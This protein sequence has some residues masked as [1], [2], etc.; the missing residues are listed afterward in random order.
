M[1]KLPLE[2]IRV[3]DFTTARA[4]S[5]ISQW[6]GIMGAEVLKIESELRPDGMR[7][8]HRFADF[9]TSKKSITLNMNKPK[10]A[11]LVK[12]LVKVSD[13]VADNFGGAVMERWGLGYSE[14]KKIKPSII[15]YTGCGW[16]RTGPY[17]ER[18]A[19]AP[20]I[21]AFTGFAFANGYVGGPPLLIGEGGW[22]DSV[23]AQHA[24]FAI[25]AALF[26][27][28]I[29]GEGQYIDLSMS[30]ATLAFIPEVVL[31]YTI[32]GK[33]MERTG[34]RDN[35]MAPHGCYRCQG[36]DKWV[37]IAVSNDDEWSAFCNAV[38]NP[39]W[40]RKEEFGDQ[41]SRWQNQDELDKLIQEWTI[42]H[43]H[44]EAMETLQKAGVIAGAS[45]D[46][47]E[48]VNDPHL[49]ERGY[50]V[51]MEHPEMGKVVRAAVPWRLSDSPK[52][53]YAPSPLLGEHNNYVFGELLGL[54]KE[55]IKQLHEEQV[56][57]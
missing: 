39:E 4:G 29:T 2:G 51:E 44:Y 37:A 31:N 57:Y 28:L 38:G 27:R 5:H 48:I 22:T 16:G 50:M 8:S 7:I 15:V 43:T 47:G 52:G 53:N 34:N 54:S 11:E 25:L 26:H 13:I 42:K 30:E 56:I 12:K 32:N 1:Q 6:L 21:D 40:T 14:L 20:V 45:L 24:V 3:V 36:E 35:F 46:I 23:S 18:P 9:N 41:L 55:E 49:K 19:Y 33:I 10:S 17:R